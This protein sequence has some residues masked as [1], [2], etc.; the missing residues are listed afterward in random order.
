MMDQ[1]NQEN[2]VEFP[3]CTPRHLAG[4][5]DLMF[6]NWSKNMVMADFDDTYSKV[7]KYWGFRA[8]N[9]FH[10]WG[11]LILKSSERSFETR[12]KGKTIGY[13]VGNY[14]LVFDRPV[15]WEQNLRILNWLA[16]ESGNEGLRKYAT[17]QAIKRTSTLRIGSKGKKSPPRIVY[18]YGSQDHQ[19]AIY[20]D[21]R[22]FLLNGIKKN[23]GIGDASS[24]SVGDSK[25]NKN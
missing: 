21:V 14:H 5:P 8:L 19:I 18:R 17:M 1:V 7:V 2:T 24:S 23:W 11:L 4:K 13:K 12:C 25:S 10:L 22:R 20:L 16:L 3:P 15:K 9:W 6:G